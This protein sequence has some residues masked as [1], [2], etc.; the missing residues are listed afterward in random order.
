MPQIIKKGSRG[1]EVSEWQNFLRGQGF[2]AVAVSGEFDEATDKA[3]REFQGVAG[4]RQDGIVGPNTLK[5]AAEKGFHIHT[6]PERL[7]NLSKPK[8]RV[9]DKGRA[10][11]KSFEREILK[12]YDDGYG[13]PTG[14]IGHRLTG[15]ELDRLPLGTPISK[16]M[17]DVWF[18]ADLKSHTEPIDRLVKVPL[19][20]GQ[21][22]ALVSLCVAPETKILTADF[23]WVEAGGV[24][25]GLPIWSV[26]EDAPDAG[27]NKTRRL[28]TALI[29][30]V[31]TFN[32]ERVRVVTDKGDIVVTPDHRFLT[33]TPTRAT[34]RW[35]RADQMS[36]DLTVKSRRR[37]GFRHGTHLI[38]YLPPWTE[39]RSFEAGYLAGFLDAEGYA[40]LIG[41]LSQRSICAGF[42]QNHGPVADAVVDGLKAKG[43]AVGKYQP[44]NKNIGQYTIQGGLPELFR[45]LGSLRPR[46][47]IPNA[48]AKWDGE[49]GL[50]ALPKAQVLGVFPEKVGEVVSIQTSSRTYFSNGLVSHNC[51]N[52][53]GKAFAKSSLLKVLNAGDYGKARAKFDEFIKSDGRVSRGLV[54]RRNEE[55]E[56][57]D[58]RD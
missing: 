10:F 31:R 52:I 56:M 58:R 54:R 15:D 39:D 17:S 47:L 46:R 42:A 18:E 3:S 34:F 50:Y 57:W 21:Y 4:L 35:T 19:T 16:L 7:D 36:A 5:A 37:G 33:R 8:M 40:T 23:R 12:I 11:I 28:R 2:A 48:I 9:S 20:Q 51:F 13:F 6:P 25:P 24:E 22:D 45:A 38:P 41:S 29:E 27:N 30:S 49:R 14:G 32:S 44:K 1:P 53:G 43:F 26:D 55:Q